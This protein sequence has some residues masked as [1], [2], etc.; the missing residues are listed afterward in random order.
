MNLS[1]I[2]H[3]GH[4]S[5]RQQGTPRSSI[6]PSADPHARLLHDRRQDMASVLTSSPYISQSP[7]YIRSPQ[8]P[9]SPPG[10]DSAART[11]PSI[12]SLIGMDRHSV[13]QEQKGKQCCAPLIGSAAHPYFCRRRNATTPFGR[14][15]LQWP[16]TAGIRSAHR[17]QP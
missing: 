2:V 17:E 6:A 10:D 4:K 14:G 13:K 9:P 12:Q 7:V 15:P 5:T 8:P 16:S 11:L 3:E 1:H